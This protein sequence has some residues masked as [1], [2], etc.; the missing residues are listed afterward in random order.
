MFE[1][2]LEQIIVGKMNSYPSR[3]TVVIVSA[4]RVHQRHNRFALGGA[5]L[6]SGVRA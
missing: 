3:A 6:E 2:N 5:R 1:G 4:R